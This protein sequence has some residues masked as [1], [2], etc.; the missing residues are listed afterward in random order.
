MDVTQAFGT[1]PR[2]HAWTHGYSYDSAKAGARR[3]LA[4]RMGGPEKIRGQRDAA[5]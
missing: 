5:G 4:E 3:M 1:A 2:C